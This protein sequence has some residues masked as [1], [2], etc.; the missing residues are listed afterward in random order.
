MGWRF[1]K[2]ALVGV[3]SGATL[4]GALAAATGAEAKSTYESPYGYERT[5]NAALRLVRVDNGWKINEKDETNGYLLFDYA[6]PAERQGDAR[7]ARAR[8]RAGAGGRRQ[9]PGAASADAAL[10]RAGHSRRARLEDA[11]RVRRPARAPTRA[12]RAP[13]PPRR[14]DG[15]RRLADARR[16][17][18]DAP[19]AQ[20]AAR[21]ASPETPG[22]ASPQQRKPIW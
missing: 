22:C 9:R 15:R 14:R 10:P 16:R 18:R 2:V 8:A 13:G 19:R 5:W 11:P 17:R 21:G 1:S 7:V 12:S 4:V 20:R 3:F 6:A